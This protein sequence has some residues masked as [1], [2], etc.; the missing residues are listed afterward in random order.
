MSPG[1]PSTVRFGAVVL[2]E[3]L[4]ESEPCQPSSQDG[5][6]SDR[7]DPHCVLLQAE[8][9][10]VTWSDPEPVSHAFRDD[11]L[12]F[13]PDPMGH[14]DQ[15]NLRVGTRPTPVVARSSW[16]TRSGEGGE[17]RPEGRRARERR[18]GGG[19]ERAG[20]GGAKDR[21]VL[22]RRR[23]KGGRSPTEAVGRRG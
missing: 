22:V 7:F 9:D 23:G 20:L 11:D 14:T 8:I 10:L 2:F 6:L 4:D 15:Y 13:G 3:D 1:S 18:R 19:G 16:R 21:K 17:G 5:L 12:A